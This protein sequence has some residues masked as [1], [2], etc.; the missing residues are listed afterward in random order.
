MDGILHSPVEMTPKDR[1]LPLI[2][3][4][5]EVCQ[6]A[7]GLSQL[8][9]TN[10]PCKTIV[11]FP[12]TA[13]EPFFNQSL[14]ASGNSTPVEIGFLME[15][16][17]R[18][19]PSSSNLEI[20]P[21]DGDLSLIQAP[22]EVCQGGV[23]FRQ[24]QGKKISLTTISA[25]PDT[26]KISLSPNSKLSTEAS[27]YDRLSQS[28][29]ST[30]YHESTNPACSAADLR[31]IELRGLPSGLGDRGQVVA[32]LGATSAPCAFCIAE[33]IHSVCGK[34]CCKERLHIGLYDLQIGGR[35]RA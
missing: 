7:V 1:G 13:H 25:S 16:N 22:L 31:V 30:P 19:P 17:F 28:E 9:G 20:T 14:R 33:T 18:P 34:N 5:L 12:D 3:A 27:I 4:S 6:G 26:A 21:K 11:N 23:G 2:R 15:T 8:P 24:L 29:A 32:M 35:C 10:L